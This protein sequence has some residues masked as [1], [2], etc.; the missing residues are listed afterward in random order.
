MDNSVKTLGLFD[1]LDP[2]SAAP[3]GQVYLRSDLNVLHSVWPVE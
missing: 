2:R 3:L 1:R